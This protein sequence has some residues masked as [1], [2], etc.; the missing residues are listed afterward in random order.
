MKKFLVTILISLSLFSCISEKKRLKICRTCAVKDSISYV[1]KE[2]IVLKDTTIFT[3]IAGPTQWL[4]NPC[5]NLCDSLGN[6][7]PFKKEKKSNGLKSTIKSVGNSIEVDCDAD[8]LKNVIGYYEKQLEKVKTQQTT[9]VSRC[10][11]EHRNKFDGFTFWWF[12]I[13]AIIIVIYLLFKLLKTKLP[14]I[15]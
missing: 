15:K 4:E 1:E 14:F 8:S 13:T 7:I 11:L 5:K 6:L 3:T 10:E 12:W 9:V 2:K